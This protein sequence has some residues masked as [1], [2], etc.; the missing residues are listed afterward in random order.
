MKSCNVKVPLKSHLRTAVLILNTANEMKNQNQTLE[1]WYDQCIAFLQ[2]WH[3][4]EILKFPLL[5]SVMCN[6][7]GTVALEGLCIYKET[8]KTLSGKY[9]NF[10]APSFLHLPRFHFLFHTQLNSVLPLVLQHLYI[11]LLSL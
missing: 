10:G 3:K 11:W 9:A 2:F 1:F 4:P 5:P 7:S 8:I 6:I